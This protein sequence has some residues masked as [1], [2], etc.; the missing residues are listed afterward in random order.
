MRHRDLNGLNVEFLGELDGVANGIA[1]FAGQAEDEV[2]VN[3]QA[4]LVTI[5]G[6]LAGAFDGGALLDVLE[7][8]LIA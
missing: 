2:T 3:Y 5:F 7:N 8:L 1:G 6:E 4:K